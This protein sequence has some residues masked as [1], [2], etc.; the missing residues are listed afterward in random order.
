VVEKMHNDHAYTV[1]QREYSDAEAR[2]LDEVK[3][4]G[5]ISVDNLPDEVPPA[6][7]EVFDGMA[8]PFVCL[9][10]AFS[11]LVLAGLYYLIKG[12]PTNADAVIA[13]RLYR[14][15]GA[16]VIFGAIYSFLI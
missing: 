3:K 12:K 1:K 7:S 4:G 13:S 8:F 15:W 9:F 5:N 10:F 14:V 16:S 2:L 11:Y 6:R